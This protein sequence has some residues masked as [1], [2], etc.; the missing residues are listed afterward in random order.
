MSLE[1][2]RIT[3]DYYDI[4]NV[5]IAFLSTYEDRGRRLLKT[6]L[7]HSEDE[8]VDFFA[9]YE[10]GFFVGYYCLILEGNFAYIQSCN[11]S[12]MFDF[13]SYYKKILRHISEKYADYQVVI[14]FPATFE[15]PEYPHKEDMEDDQIWAQYTELTD[16]QK[17]INFFLNSGFYKTDFYNTCN[18]ENFEIF[19]NRPDFQSYG[20]SNAF[21]KI[22]KLIVKLDVE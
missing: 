8:S 20:A 22:F 4:S 16:T 19:C 18:G 10:D 3:K 13:T 2:K 15:E 5:K 17:V 1:S 21:S 14:S 6:L 9:V 11:I 12:H 7:E